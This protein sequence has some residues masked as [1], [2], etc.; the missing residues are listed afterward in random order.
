MIMSMSRVRQGDGREQ[1]SSSPHS[2]SQHN[3]P[4]SEH[5]ALRI[6]NLMNWPPIDGAFTPTKDWVSSFR[7]RVTA[8]VNQY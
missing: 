2:T 8:S 3:A 6:H 1:T 4:F 5:G 7:S